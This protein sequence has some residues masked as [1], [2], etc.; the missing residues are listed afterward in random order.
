MIK[1]FLSNYGNLTNGCIELKLAF[2]LLTM[3]RLVEDEFILQIDNETFIR[4]IMYLIILTRGIIVKLKN[5]N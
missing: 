2:L 1:G 3:G 4:V 5:I